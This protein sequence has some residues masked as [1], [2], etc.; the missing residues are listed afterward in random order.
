[1]RGDWEELEGRQNASLEGSGKFVALGVVAMLAFLAWTQY[2]GKEPDAGNSAPA[3]EAAVVPSPVI[4]PPRVIEAPAS[5]TQG[6]PPSVTGRESYVGV[7]ECEVNGQRVVSDRPCAPDAQARTL[8]IDQPDPREVARQRQMT[9]SAQ[10]SGSTFYA[11]PS[12]GSSTSRA[13]SNSAASNEA[14]CEAVDR[15]IDNL[16][17][18]MRQRYGA[19]EGERLRAQWHDLKQRRYELE[20]GR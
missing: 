10:R 3:I 18:R 9:P 20:C 17:A 13:G 16:N 6:P 11:N 14:A 1:M 2:F 15:A 5:Y 4:E 12:G 7:Y 8:V 19:A